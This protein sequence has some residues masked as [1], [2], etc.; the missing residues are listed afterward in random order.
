MS[1]RRPSP[2]DRLAPGAGG[3]LACAVAPLQAVLP[4]GI[5]YALTS[6]L[7]EPVLAAGDDHGTAADED[8]FD[9]FG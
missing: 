9:A 3:P 2:A 8:A 1:S 7:T 6:W 4:Y 5:G